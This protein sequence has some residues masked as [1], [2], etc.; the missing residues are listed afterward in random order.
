MSSTGRIMPLPVSYKDRIAAIDGVSIVGP[1][2]WFGGVYQDP[3]NFFAQIAVE[4]EPFLKIY[5]EFKL[6]R[7]PQAEAVV[8]AL[9]QEQ[10]KHL[11]DPRHADWNALCVAAAQRVV[12]EL[13]DK[14]GGLAARTW[15]ERNT[16]SIRHPLS[17]AVPLLARLL[18]MPARALPGDSNMPRVQGPEFGA[19]QRKQYQAGI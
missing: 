6:P 5:P 11:L 13:G 15:G 17:R 1:Q 12:A 2:T 14:P 8:W 10:P 9:L 4:P 7:L 18:D 3:A 16:T 19:S